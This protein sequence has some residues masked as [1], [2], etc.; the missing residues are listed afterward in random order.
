M[1][2]QERRERSNEIDREINSLFLGALS[3]SGCESSQVSLC[4]VGGYGRGELSPGS[5][6]DLLIVHDS[7]MAA[8]QLS[9][10]VNAILYPLWNSSRSVDHS[11]RTISQ[12]EESASTDIRVAMGLLDARYLAG[13]ESLAS[14][15]ISNAKT[16]WIKN[17]EN[18]RL[19]VKAAVAAR[20]E[21]SG[22]LAYLLE[23]DLKEARGGLRDITTL[24]AIARS[25]VV[26]VALDRVS[27]A[28]A[29]LMAVRDSLHTVTGRNR[30]HLLLTDQDAVA[31][32]LKFIDA[33]HLM[34]EVAKA[35]RSVDYVMDLTW[36]QMEH[37]ERKSFWR[38]SQER[39]I[40]K[41]LIEVGN[42]VRL[43][44]GVDISVDP[45]I[46]LRAAALSAQ[47][48][49]P[50]SLEACTMIAKNF[51]ALPTPWPRQSREDLVSL[52]GSGLEMIQ[53]FEALDQEGLIAR[54]IPEWEHV[55]FLPQRNVLHRHTVDRHMLETAVKAASLTRE[56]RR[57]DL[58]LVGALFHDIGKG[59]EGKDHSLFGAELI[60][61]L[62]Q[63]LGFSHEDCQT[64]ALLVKEH[65]LLP[66]IATRRDLDDPQ[67]INS[68]VE[69]IPD[70]DTLELLHALS[71]ADGE[72]TGKSAWSSW[73]A[74][75]VSDLV[76]RSLAVMQG[77]PPAPKP[78][79]TAAAIE[80]VKI[81]ELNVEVKRLDE[82]HE[83]EIVSPDQ[84]GL[85]SIVAGVLSILR[86]DLRSART[87]TVDGVAVMTWIVALDAYAQDPDAVRI[88][89]NL[90]R[91]LAG[92]LDIEAKLEDRMRNYR[93]YPGILVPPPLVTAMND[94]ATDATVLE[95]R[96]H[97]RPGLLFDLA[98]FIS[99]CG[100]DIRAA[101]VATLG[102]EA[103]D[104]FY[105]TDGAGR[106][107]SGQRT[108]ELIAQ[109]EGHVGQR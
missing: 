52:I 36:H 18:Y 71:I 7:K 14:A 34:L 57:P 84:R 60:Y 41:G 22:E 61:P 53:V 87:R 1:G 83:I 64:L 16:S 38:R 74:G 21:V 88:L 50:L 78:E 2:T 8:D 105:I 30:D 55:R 6:I 9:S 107:L 48:G 23:P 63:R 96:M 47:R 73:K 13:S 19:E 77:A 85:L 17:F 68:V 75:L 32:D 58:L 29:L 35:A 33:D 3:L 101:I 24:R 93:R 25:Q 70:A 100:V 62:A 66:T 5:D 98:S 42:E 106:A 27:A 59:Y 40:G 28:E 82:V 109:I 72:A 15:V 69:V 86:M 76:Q 49:I 45:G 108:N 80:K 43:Q 4:A 91:A 94:L 31:E 39:V 104:T 11:V 81:G 46:G 92:E 103:F 12:T 89:E 54:W 10:F 26:P 65:L 37:R 99:T 51:A 102:A 90:Q 97:D 95:V 56:V 67:T 44:D 79:L 20:A